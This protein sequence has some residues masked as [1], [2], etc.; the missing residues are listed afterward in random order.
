MILRF[1]QI[2]LSLCTFFLVSCQTVDSNTLFEQLR[3]TCGPAQTD[4]EV[5]ISVLRPEQTRYSSECLNILDAALPID[6]L[7]FAQARSGLKE[8]VLEGFAGLALTP[9]AMPPDNR[10]LGTSPLEAGAIPLA[11][12]RIFEGDPGSNLNQNAFNY[13]VGKFV[14]IRFVD[15]QLTNLRAEFNGGRELIIYPKFWE[16][17]SYWTNYHMPYG[18]SATLLHEA[19]HGDTIAHVVCPPDSRNAGQSE[20]DPEIKGAFGMGLVYPEL[21]LQGSRHLLADFSLKML[22]WLMCVTVQIS[23]DTYEEIEGLF[24]GRDCELDST[25]DWIKKQEGWESPS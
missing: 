23:L 19:R 15:N 7:S 9:I 4:E 24:R 2:S 10:I 1:F 25:A 18:A 3:A 12:W 22:G 11:F 5:F 14:S 16:A 21:I 8:H 20:C 6:H 13:V 17:D